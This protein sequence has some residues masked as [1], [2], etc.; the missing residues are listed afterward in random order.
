MENI[1]RG[2]GTKLI[3][4]GQN[5]IENKRHM[6]PPLILDSAMPID[7]ISWG[8]DL[9]RNE[10]INGFFY[11]RYSNPTVKILEE[12]IS[13]LEEAEAS[14]TC[15]SGMTAVWLAILAL[16]NTGDDILIPYNVY[17]E[18][19][20]FL[21]YLKKI[22]ISV[23]LV[24]M[25][26]I[27]SIQ[28]AINEN[29]KMIFIES[30]T[31]PMLR[32]LDISVIASICKKKSI[33]FVVDNTMLTPYGQQPLKMGADLSLHSTTK[34]LNGH[35]D[36]IGGILC[37][38]EKLISEIKKLSDFAGTI[39]PPFNAWLTIRGLKT[40]DVR[41][42]RHCQNAM[43]L[44]NY[45]SRHPKVLSVTYPGLESFGQ[46]ALVDKQMNSNG[47][48]VTF[49]IR[50][51]KLAGEQFLRNIRMCRVATTFGNAETVVYHFATF[52]RPSRDIEKIGEGLGSIR[53]SVGLENIDDIIYDFQN[54]LKETIVGEVD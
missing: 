13:S 27:E 14:I 21:F 26:N 32:I 12:K 41:M 48:I 8:I 19:S 30:P 36:A 28:S 7:D 40:L 18:I 37:G 43:E 9:L 22:N 44:A 46:K 33:Y 38:S 29:T 17:H 24:D 54:A 49:D 10:K 2:F 6:I 53:C 42:C 45:L 50:G 34:F 15:S 4:D 39:M 35:G 16:C 51:G 5:S 1:N 25:E 20:D 11:S 31:N 47:G 52:A 3:H 23:S